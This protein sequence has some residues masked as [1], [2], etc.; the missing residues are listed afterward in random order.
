LWSWLFA[1]REVRREP[2]LRVLLITIDTLRADA[3]GAYGNPR[4][5]TPWIDRLAAAGIR[6]AEARAHNVTTLPS[7][8]NILAGRY[9]FD[10]GVRD[11]G[12][13]RFPSTQDTLATLLSARGYRTGA[14]VSAFPLDSRFGLDRGFDVY[15]DSVTGAEPQ[16][17]F[18]VQERAGVETVA[19]ARAWLDTPDPR[20]A[21]C[22]I[23]LYEPHFPYPRGYEADVSAAD[24]ALAPL[25]APILGDARAP[26]GGLP[27]EG[28]D[29]TL[30]VLTSDHGESLGEH[31][32]STHGIFAY[33][34]TLLVPLVLHAPRLLRPAVLRGAA[35][36]VDILPTILDAIDVP[37]PAGL[38]GR[39]L[40]PLAAG[41]REAPVATY[42]EA[43]SG[44][45]NRGWA[46]LY[47]VVRG[48]RKFID[49]PIPELFDLAADPSEQRNL[50]DFHPDGLRELHGVLASIRPDGESVV[51][52]AESADT[53]EQLRSLG[54]VAHGSADRP[55]GARQS[56]GPRDADADTRVDAGSTRFEEADDPK[57]L[58]GLDAL[59]QEVVGR[60]LDGDLGGALER[61]RELVR[62]RPSMAVSLLHL[63]H[64]ERAGG[65]LGAGID[66]LKKALALAP[67]DA[68]ALSLLGAYLGEAGRADE[69]VAWLEEAARRSD[70]DP[71]V[72]VS[73][74]LALA[75][76]GR[77]E[78][79][80]APFDR[81]VAQDPASPK[82]LVERGT[83]HM[84]AGRRERA[85]LDFEAAVAQPPAP[86]RAYTSL[87]VLAVEDGRPGEAL[88]H[89]H[90]AVTLDP[91]EHRTL[92]ALG[93]FHWRA[94]RRDAARPYL[95]FFAASAPPDR[96]E[97][98]LARVRDMRTV[99]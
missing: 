81:A 38:P 66:A 2:G 51:R 31:G 7:H 57:R 48:S 23:H 56:R 30:V 63:A 93:L 1:P 24:A 78:Q 25:L 49:L 61:C 41:E 35:R 86:S 67:D 58:I 91:G 97:R 3:V 79:A 94:G 14:F 89:W 12:G 82:L 70:A 88:A 11:N 37:A 18:L 92:L 13:F 17:A 19:R 69:A 28:V 40:L 83:A 84:M 53:L 74:G 39:S 85:R 10:H 8:A 44:Q 6:F 62:R 32:E 29:R 22:W 60:Y 55:R 21:F 75:K 98:E 59:L 68:N 16:T 77:H 54:Y 87:G 43:L 9:P 34:S 73:Y 72:L 90:R 99:R 33:D 47:G 26:A 15:D 64:L 52:T 42:F 96:Y 50:A 95:D 65:D 27:K 71:Q 5:H 4:A 76:L 80:L 45:L 46:P 36:H 20:P